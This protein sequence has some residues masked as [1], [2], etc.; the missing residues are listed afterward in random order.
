MAVEYGLRCIVEANKHTCGGCHRAG[1]TACVGV[2][3]FTAPDRQMNLKS[4]TRATMMTTII[5]RMAFKSARHSPRLRML[6]Q[7][8]ICRCGQMCFR[9][10]GVAWEL[11]TF[12]RLLLM[13]GVFPPLATFNVPASVMVPDEVT[14]PPDVVNPVVPPDTPTL[15]TVPVP[16]AA[17][18][19]H[20]VP[21]HA[22]T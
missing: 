5:N 12:H 7:G 15:V 17:V 4:I 6:H 9:L 21:F 20:A 22:R 18:G 14:G 13:V 8:P 10:C 16:P 2:P 3:K 11:R 19:V 1:T